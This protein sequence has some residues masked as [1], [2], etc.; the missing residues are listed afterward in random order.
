MW[1]CSLIERLLLIALMLMSVSLAGPALAQ[2]AP[3]SDEQGTDV[4][5][6]T[7]AVE[8]QGE[9]EAVPTDD[10]SYL[11]IDEEDFTPSEEIPADQS[12]PFPTDI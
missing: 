4:E 3:E 2:D 9:E 10:E 12:I 6:P 8:E 7:D 1:R 5:V 11:D